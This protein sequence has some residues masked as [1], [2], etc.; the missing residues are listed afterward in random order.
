MFYPVLQTNNLKKKYCFTRNIQMLKMYVT[1][2]KNYLD[3]L[4]TVCKETK[5]NPTKTSYIKI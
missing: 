2:H 1:Y 3:I 4:L 5:K